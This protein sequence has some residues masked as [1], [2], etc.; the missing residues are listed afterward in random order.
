[1]SNSNATWLNEVRAMLEANVD[2]ENI[3]QELADEVHRRFMEY[4]QPIIIEYYVRESYGR[5]LE[6]IADPAQNRIIQN[7]TRQKTIDSVIRELLRDLTGGAI[8]W[9]Q[10]LA[11]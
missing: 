6:Y 3:S 4:R 9:K 1:M 7:L 10:V 11:P 5:K 2:T 8:I